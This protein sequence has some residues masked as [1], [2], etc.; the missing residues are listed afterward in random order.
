[1]EPQSTH[2]ENS[3]Q[4]QPSSQQALQQNLSVLPQSEEGVKN[5]QA[6]PKFQSPEK[7]AKVSERGD[8]S[9]IE[10]SGT[11]AAVEETPNRESDEMTLSEYV[12]NFEAEEKL[13]EQLMQNKLLD[14]CRY[15]EGY[16]YQQVYACITCYQEQL[17]SLPDDQRKIIEA[18]LP[19]NGELVKFVKPHGFCIGCMVHCHEGHDVI[20]L[21]SKL[22]FRCDCGN[23]RMPQACK[24]FNDKEDYE[25]E[26]NVYNHNYFDCYCY[27]K[28]P[29][30]S[31]YVDQY[32]IQCYQ[33]EDWF[34]NQHLTPIIQKE[35]EEEYFLL[36]KDCVGQHFGEILPAYQA[37]FHQDSK[38]H[39]LVNPEDESRLKRKKLDEVIDTD[40]KI[41]CQEKIE[42]Q[43]NLNFQPFDVLLS[44]SFLKSRCA[45]E[46]CSKAFSK[47]ERLIKAIQ[48][49]SKD[50]KRLQANLDGK[51]DDEEEKKED[52]QQTSPRSAQPFVQKLTSDQYLNEVFLR[53][54]RQQQI[55]HEGQIHI[56]Q[57]MAK[58]KEQFVSFLKRF[59]NQDKKVTV[60]DV[61]EFKRG[62]EQIRESENSGGFD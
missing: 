34:H 46:R 56:A 62:L 39:M 31:E 33:C 44:E 17:Y 6:D 26:A 28:K 15:Q 49:M 52:A 45:C 27:C 14:K 35:I 25:N 4:E 55:S 10:E 40:K 8:K 1:M 12:K 7:S 61:E 47:I 23:G 42:S 22:E 57:N 58:F 53:T 60:K 24:L 29:H 37:Y 38:D 9:A 48:G 32:M 20:E 54:V 59:E 11:S 21:Y 2:P 50:E 51:L 5:S 41:N 16:I 36:C 19:N 13:E 43:E 18:G 3:Q 30:S